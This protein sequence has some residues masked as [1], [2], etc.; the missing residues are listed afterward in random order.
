MYW[1]GPFLFGKARCQL[2][3]RQPAARIAPMARNL[4]CGIEDKGTR[5]HMLVRDVQRF[6]AP[7]PAAPEHNIDIEHPRPP[8]LPALLPPKCAFDRLQRV[9]DI[10]RG[11]RSF[12]HGCAIGKAS[13][14]RTDGCAGDGRRARDHREPFI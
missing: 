3:Q 10:G 12:D 1:L 11:E 4:R 7:D 8:G 14:R 13:L 2:S 5:V 6:A 9:Q